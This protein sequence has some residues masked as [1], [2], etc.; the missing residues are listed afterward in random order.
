MK[1]SARKPIGA[2]HLVVLTMVGAALIWT[3]PVAFAA[4][5]NQASPVPVTN[6]GAPNQIVAPAGPS[7]Q[8]TIEGVIQALQ[9]SENADEPQLIQ[10]NDTVIQ[11]PKGANK[12]GLD[13]G[14]GVR[15]VGQKQGDRLIATTVTVLAAPPAPVNFEDSN[16]NND[17]GNHGDNAGDN[18]NNDNGNHGDNA[19]DNDNNDNGNNG[20]NGDNKNNSNDNR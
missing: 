9:F 16:D 2:R 14:A 11:L 5:G 17:N 10:V 18:D 4:P 20:D 15:A 19:G 3:L 13:F 6:P 8:I 12:K 1:P 7:N